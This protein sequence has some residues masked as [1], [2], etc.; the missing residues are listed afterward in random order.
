MEAGRHQATVT[1]STKLMRELKSA[2]SVLKLALQNP[3][4]GVNGEPDADQ[5]A[6]KEVMQKELQELVYADAELEG[7]LLADEKS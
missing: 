7:L 5:L 2:V 1:E 6:A 4:S 3:S